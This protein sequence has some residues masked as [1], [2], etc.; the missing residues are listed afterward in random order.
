MQADACGEVRE[1][2]SHGWKWSGHRRDIRKA[3][4][5]GRKVASCAHRSRTALE[6]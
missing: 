4:T 1:E 5:M 2:R 6:S 3:K